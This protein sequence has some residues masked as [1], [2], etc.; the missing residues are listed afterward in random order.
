MYLDQTSGFY[1]PKPDSFG[2]KT[3]CAECLPQADVFS[4]SAKPDQS[5]LKT[6]SGNGSSSPV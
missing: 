2:V 1:P 6:K 5:F 4:V 3:V